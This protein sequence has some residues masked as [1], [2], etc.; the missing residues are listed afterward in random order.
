MGAATHRPKREE[1]IIQIIHCTKLTVCPPPPLTRYLKPY[2]W[3]L[4]RTFLLPNSS[5]STA[6]LVSLH[7]YLSSLFPPPSISLFSS[8]SLQS[9]LWGPLIVVRNRQT[10]PHECAVVNNTQGAGNAQ[11]LNSCGRGRPLQNSFHYR[12]NSQAQSKSTF[13]FIWPISHAS[14]F[15][16]KNH[17]VWSNWSMTDGYILNAASFL[18]TYLTTEVNPS[19]RLCFSPVCVTVSGIS[20][21]VKHWVMGQVIS[22]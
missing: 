18:S 2:P 21:Q 15:C 1:I 3:L 14:I 13:C 5:F 17:W 22:C 12:R 9:S 16:N 11:Q 7:F 10:R 19:R 8:S 20:P 6:L 4:N